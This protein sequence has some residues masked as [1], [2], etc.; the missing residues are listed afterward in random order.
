MSTIR[1]ELTSFIFLK[2]LNVYISEYIPFGTNHIIAFNDQ[3][4]SLSDVKDG[5]MTSIIDSEP[6]KATFSV[7]EKLIKVTVTDYD[8][9][10]YVIFNASIVYEEVVE[11]TENI[12]V[13]V[14]THG[15]VI[16]GCNIEEIDSDTEK[17]SIDKLTRVFADIILDTSKMINSL[18]STY[19]RRLL[20]LVYFGT[21]EY[22]NKFVILTAK[23]I[24][25]NK[26]AAEFNDGEDLE[27]ELNQILSITTD[28]HDV[29]T[30]NDKF[31]YG[32]EGMIIISDEPEKYEELISIMAFYFALDIFQKNYFD[33]MF[34]L[35]DDLN[36]A[37]QLIDMC[38]IDPNSTGIAKSILSQ[39]SASVVLMN[40][41]LAFMEKSVKN[42]NKE[43]AEFDRA[44]PDIQEVIKV[45]NLDDMVNKALIRI[46]DARMVVSGL[47]E[48]INGINGLINSL[49]EKQMTRMNETLKDSIASMDEVNR[50][51]ERTGAAL[52]VLEI[53][54]AGSIA[55]DVLMLLIGQY[56]VDFFANWV[57]E[58]IAIWLMFCIVAFFSV[59]F[60]LWRI[61]KFM[62]KKSEPNLRVKIN[63][64]KKCNIANFKKFLS[65]Q[66]IITRESQ[67]LADN[68]IEEF[69]WE[70]K[71]SKWLGNEVRVKLKADTNNHYILNAIVNIDKPKN[72][73]AKQISSIFSE[74]LKKENIY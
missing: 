13:Y 42:M 70:E 62:E 28:F 74:Y 33:K 56:Q 72:I 10:D 34:M 37:R 69:T 45:I 50:S 64:T 11:Q 60:G 8:P 1:D 12:C 73:N 63:I 5:L 49:A 7:E 35:W 23:N 27:N 67:I 61:I 53:I 32:S 52:N 57:K 26:K 55:F 21:P 65:K 18:L 36:K 29:T 4:D 51:S 20:D 3:L 68:T 58:N 14:D 22:R 71:D 17:F 54:L 40:E 6:T 48:E 2:D 15:R 31:F 66:T 46:E 16:Y 41:L 43:W 44:N 24:I 38:D 25:P 39:V 30:S 59:G 47:I 9:N 19:Q